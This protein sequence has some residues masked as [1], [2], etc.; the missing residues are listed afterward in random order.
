MPRNPNRPLAPISERQM[1]EPTL[2]LVFEDYKRYRKIKAVTLEK[3]ESMLLRCLPDWLDRN[4]NDIRKDEIL[5]RHTALS[6]RNGP[7]GMGAA[8]ANRVFAVLRAIY[9]F[10]EGRYEDA[11]LEPVVRRNPVNVLNACR[12]WN[13]SSRRSSIIP[14]HKMKA[15]FKEVQL[16]RNDS[17][18]DYLTFIYLTGCRRSEAAELRWQWIDLELGVVNFPAEAVKNFCE[19]SL[20][21]SGYLWFMLRARKNRPDADPVWVFPGSVKGNHISNHLKITDKIFATTGINW[22]VHDLRRGYATVANS[23]VHSDLIL[24]RLLNHKTNSR[25]VTAGYVISDVDSLREPVEAIA[26][27]ILEYSG[28]KFV[29]YFGLVEIEN[30]AQAENQIQEDLLLAAL[31]RL[32][33]DT[34]KSI[35]TAAIATSP[36]ENVIDFVKRA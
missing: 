14:K 27:K 24:K 11:M 36:S 19:F 2:R 23:C 28:F 1:P 33:R 12:A 5:E 3:Y 13:K 20:P 7:R 35:A 15:W 8:E 32:D 17:I 26:A 21:L 34:L 25:D 29:P 18:R 10:A 16:Y 6:Q 4:L 22:S 30:H 31:K 9:R